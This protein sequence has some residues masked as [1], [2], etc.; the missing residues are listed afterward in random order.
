MIVPR[1]GRAVGIDRSATHTNTRAHFLPLAQQGNSEQRTP[2]AFQSSS[3]SIY[4][5][6]WSPFTMVSS[7]FTIPNM[8]QM[9]VA[10]L[11]NTCRVCRNK[12]IVLTPALGVIVVFQCGPTAPHSRHT[13]RSLAGWGTFQWTNYLDWLQMWVWLKQEREQPQMTSQSFVCKQGKTESSPV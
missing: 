1:S 7:L 12:A 9:L 11:P 10:T 13:Q 3:F 4:L 5:C 8:S 2:G 6:N